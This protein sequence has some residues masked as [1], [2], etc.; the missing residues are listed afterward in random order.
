LGI[1]DP[2]FFGLSPGVPESPFIF[3]VV[4]A[5]F[6]FSYSLISTILYKLTETG[7]RGSG[8]ILKT[9]PTGFYYSTYRYIWFWI[10]FKGARIF[11]TFRCSK[12]KF[13]VALWRFSCNFVFI[14][15]LRKY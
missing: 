7:I 8:Y 13:V 4:G 6:D 5:F 2:L 11:P 10:R 9:F 3:I 15:F 1:S 14:F 12:F